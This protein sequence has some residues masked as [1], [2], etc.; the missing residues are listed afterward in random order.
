MKSY[1]VEQVAEHN[2]AKDIW[3]I[4]DGKVFDLT[5]FINDH[6]GGKKILLKKAGKDATKEFNTFHN[7]AIM[8]RVGL[9][10]QIGVIEQ[11]NKSKL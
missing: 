7:D 6:P 8:Q 4:V 2:T 11:S 3:V 10:M 1:T 9:P 5:N